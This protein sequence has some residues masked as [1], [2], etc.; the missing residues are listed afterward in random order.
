MGL[1]L[2]NFAFIHLAKGSSLCSRRVCDSLLTPLEEID[3]HSHI[4]SEYNSALL[5][6]RK[7]R[8]NKRAAQKM[9]N[10]FCRVLHSLCVFNLAR[11]PRALVRK[12][13]VENIYER[14]R[15]YI[16]CARGKINRI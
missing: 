4:F 7:S 15:F 9:I 12:P 5:R 3:T 2:P 11:A 10:D 13:L 1:V 8:S 16:L 14:T 6:R